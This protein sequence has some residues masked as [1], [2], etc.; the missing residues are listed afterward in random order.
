MIY[1]EIK[2]RT[3]FLLRSQRGKPRAGRILLSWPLVKPLRPRLCEEELGP[4]PSRPCQLWRAFIWLKRW[5]FCPSQQLLRMLW[6]SG[7]D[8]T[9]LTWLGKPRCLYGEK[10]T[11]LVGVATP[12]FEARDSGLEGKFGI[13]IMRGRWNTRNNPRDYGIVQNCVGIAEFKPQSNLS[14]TYR[15]CCRALIH[16]HFSVFLQFFHL[17]GLQ[18]SRFFSLKTSFQHAKSLSFDR[19]HVLDLRENRR[20]V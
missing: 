6:L 19:S 2:K 3:P 12:L 17:T 13:E 10:L 5:P 8:C 14:K 4:S 9:E 15:S 18:N 7:L 16:F 1:Y 20:D 11:R